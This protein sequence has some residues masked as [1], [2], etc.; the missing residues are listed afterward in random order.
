MDT[1][2]Q[3]A[4]MAADRF[5]EKLQNGFFKKYRSLNNEDDYAAGKEERD[6]LAVEKFAGSGLFNELLER[7]GEGA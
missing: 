3:E 6:T 7:S 2:N 5:F 1:K 4:K